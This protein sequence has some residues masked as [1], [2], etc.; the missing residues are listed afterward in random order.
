MDDDQIRT[1][2]SDLKA[3]LRRFERYVAGVGTQVPVVAPPRV[4]YH[5]TSADGFSGILTQRLLRATNFS[6]M[7][8][9]SEVGYGRSVVEQVLKAHKSDPHAASSHLA[10][11]ALANVRAQILAEMYVCCFT[12]LS[13]DISQWRA[14]G[15]GAAARYCLGFDTEILSKL[16]AK[17]PDTVFDRVVYDERAQAGRVTAVLIKAMEFAEMEK[18]SPAEIE[19]VAEVLASYLVR[20][21]CLL[22]S[23]AYHAEE[24]WRIVT[25]RAQAN[26]AEIAFDASRG[27]I[28]PYWRLQLA[29]RWRLPISSVRVLAPSRP[30]AAVKAADLMLRSV[31]IPV[32]AQYSSVPYAE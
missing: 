8:D 28:K 17:H 14:Y 13:D 10:R 3:L 21:V 27:T 6:F 22:K 30:Q 15:S 25:V 23:P 18:L 24:E 9:P 4:V 2:T 19:P 26:T 29:N 11:R 32:Q 12:T 16:V 31:G 5:Y 7:N 1:L 20:L